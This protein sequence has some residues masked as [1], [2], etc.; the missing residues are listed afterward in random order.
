L[1]AKVPAPWQRRPRAG[2]WPAGCPEGTRAVASHARAPRLSEWAPAFPLLA[3]AHLGLRPPAVHLCV[4][5]GPGRPTGHGQR[6]RGRRLDPLTGW[7]R[8]R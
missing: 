7:R 1:P 6:V 3:G 5:S 8:G 4:R 2:S